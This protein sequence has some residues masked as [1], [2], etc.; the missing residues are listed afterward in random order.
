LQATKK[1]IA[2][3]EGGISDRAL[4]VSTV[5]AAAEIAGSEAAPIAVQ[6]V[7]VVEGLGGISTSHA[8]VGK[9]LLLAAIPSR[10]LLV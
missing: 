6:L 5:P 7:A 3:N 2:D 1:A 8:V 9:L 4:Q 10:G